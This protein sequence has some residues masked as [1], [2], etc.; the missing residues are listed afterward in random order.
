MRRSDKRVSDL[1][2]GFTLVEL[3]VVLVILAIVAAIAVPT[4]LAYID[5]AQDKVVVSE[6]ESALKAT[7]TA[8]SEIYNLGTNRLTPDKRNNVKSKAGSPAKSQFVVWTGA[9][10]CDGVTEVKP[11][12]LASF[13]VFY[14]Q[15]TSEDGRV[16]F[17]NGKQWNVYDTEQQMRD[18]DSDYSKIVADNVIYMW[19]YKA[20]SAYNNMLQIETYKEKEGGT[21]GITNVSINLH[22]Y[23]YSGKGVS[24][25]DDSGTKEESIAVVYTFTDGVLSKN[26]F[27]Y[28]V[29]SHT[30]KIGNYSVST[31]KGFEVT[32]WSLSNPNSG[33]FEVLS[34]DEITAKVL[35]GEITEGQDIYTCAVR[36]IAKTSVTFTFADVDFNNS[37][38]WFDD[39][40]NNKT[41]SVTIEL[42]KY[43]N[44][45][46]NDYSKNAALNALRLR[47]SEE[48]GTLGDVCHIKVGLQMLWNDA[49]QIVADRIYDGILYGHSVIDNHVEVEMGACR[50]R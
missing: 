9:E 50:Y 10:L 4:F 12:N 31:D 20:D 28:D 47:L 8:L 49:Y 6:A 13:T 27:N 44:D 36:T 11:S 17:Y 25:A 42:Q 16:A 35:S 39:G 3:L 45:I 34:T 15:Y 2:R 38:I 23:D 30:G 19:D 46:D 48:L 32:G 29:S 1:N 22:G 37:F 24:F 21:T 41:K 18:R 7:E 33:S 5:K 43:E 40:N 26:N 14:A